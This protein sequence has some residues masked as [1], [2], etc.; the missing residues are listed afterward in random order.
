MHSWLPIHIWQKIIV[1]GNSINFRFR[2]WI[3]CVSYYYLILSGILN[4]PVCISCIIYY[5]WCI[6]LLTNKCFVTCSFCNWHHCKPDFKSFFVSGELKNSS[7][8]CLWSVVQNTSPITNF[9]INLI[10]PLNKDG[11]GNAKLLL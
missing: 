11:F 4:L 7:C 10:S 5:H 9:L 3:F 1:H 2:F 8:L 6:N